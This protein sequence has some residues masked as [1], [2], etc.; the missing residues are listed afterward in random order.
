MN[1]NAQRLSRWERTESQGP[2]RFIVTRGVLGLGLASAVVLGL[3]ELLFEHTPGRPLFQ[4]DAGL[5]RFILR[6]ALYAIVMGSVWGWMLWNNMRKSYRR[7]L[8]EGSR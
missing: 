5:A 7:T 4:D 3:M 2:L 1:M 6:Y 8:D